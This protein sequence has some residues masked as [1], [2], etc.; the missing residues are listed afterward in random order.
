M[1][2]P[3]ETP[4]RIQEAGRLPDN[5]L[6]FARTLRGAGLRV[7]PASVVD[8]VR[9]VAVA[10][11]TDRDDFYWVL[12]SVFVTRHEDHAVFDEAFRLYW[13]SRELVEK[14]LQ[15][16]SP[17]TAG[18]DRAEERRAGQTRV[19]QSL[20]SGQESKREVEK[21]EIEIDALMTASGREVLRKKDFAQMTAAELAT[22]R[23]AMQK[24]VLPVHP[25]RTRRHRPVNRIARMDPRRTLSA[26][27]RS[28]GD[29]VLPKFREVRKIHP[30]LVILADISGS[31]ANYSRTFLHFIHALAE[32]RRKVNTFLFGTRLTNVT[33]QLRNKDIDEALA[34][35]TDAVED[36]SGGTRIGTTLHEF[37]HKWSRRVLGQGAVVLLITDGL[38]RD[39]DDGLEREIDRLHRSCRRLIWLNPLLRFEGFRAR[40]KG[41]RTMLPHVD[42]F[43]PVHSLDALADLCLALSAPSSAR[44]DPRSWLEAMRAA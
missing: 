10:G 9:A 31:M 39:E 27:L 8:A 43:R 17:S 20:F 33:R 4:N 24:L 3:V 2:E 37:N 15:M 21:P 13:R 32:S 42:E 30:P 19:S 40:A 38:E 25:V 34:E 36:W 23:I 22:A 41:I 5:I 12:H 44:N 35:C 28:G 11:M 14:M 29:L 1:S 6:Y 7:G 18:R 26:S 16:F